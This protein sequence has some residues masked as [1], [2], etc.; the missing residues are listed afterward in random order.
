MQQEQNKKRG[1][2]AASGSLWSPLHTCVAHSLE[3]IRQ[4]ETEDKPSVR[5]MLKKFLNN[6]QNKHAVITRLFLCLVL[7]VRDKR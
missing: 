3:T 2:T 1:P 4:T 5:K 7:Y 6:E